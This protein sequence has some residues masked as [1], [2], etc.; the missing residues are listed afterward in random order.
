MLVRFGDVRA[1]ESSW[2]GVFSC[3]LMEVM[4]LGD[5]LCRKNGWPCSEQ[6]TRGLEKEKQSRERGL[7]EDSPLWGYC[8]VCM[9]PK[10]HEAFTGTGHS[11]EEGLRRACRKASVGLS[12]GLPLLWA[13]VLVAFMACCSE[14]RGQSLGLT[15]ITWA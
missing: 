8:M 6:T 15:W 2:G 14:K 11:R 7:G 4:L 3:K 5:E 13:V 9:E 10:S 12:L 1:R